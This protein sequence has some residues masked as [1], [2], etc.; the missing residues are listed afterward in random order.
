MSSTIFRRPATADSRGVKAE[1]TRTTDRRTGIS[2]EGRDAEAGPWD[3]AR[4]EEPRLEG[5]E[6]DIAVSN[7]KGESR[8]VVTV[9]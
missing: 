3:I 6:D 8:L 2:P 4:D 9:G 7:A 1:D 5:I